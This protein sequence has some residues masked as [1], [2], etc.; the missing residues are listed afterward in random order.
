MKAA[1]SEDFSLI[2]S[3]RMPCPEVIVR[4]YRLGLP[5]PRAN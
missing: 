2:A 1:K 5:A 3:E 4:P